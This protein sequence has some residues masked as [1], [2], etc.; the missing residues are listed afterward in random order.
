MKIYTS[1]VNMVSQI[2]FQTH[3]MKVAFGL[4]Q[5]TFQSESISDL[6]YRYE[7][8]NTTVVGKSVLTDKTTGRR[9]PVAI[10]RN[11]DSENI[12]VY[13]IVELNKDFIDTVGAG[14]IKLVHH[15]DH[16][17]IQ[18]MASQE[19]HKKGV[20]SLL[21]QIA[22]ERSMQLGKEGKV[23]FEADY[24][25]EPFH[26]K[27]GYRVVHTADEDY[28]KEDGENDWIV[29][30]KMANEKIRKIVEEAEAK[31]EIPD[32]QNK[33]GTHCEFAMPANNMLIWSEKIRK[34]PCLSANY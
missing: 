25:S 13:R 34:S 11:D 24:D 15:N 29:T 32:S 7:F 3:K 5:D 21:H 9:I 1:S 22:I 19:P 18:K 14:Y 16:E 12:E 17:F 26:Y 31:G 28:I 8:R 10:T 33:I 4:N 27:S 20:G 6:N 30:A 2:K 23:E